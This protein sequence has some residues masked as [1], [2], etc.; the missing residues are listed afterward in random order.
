[1]YPLCRIRI[2]GETVVALPNTMYGLGTDYSFIMRTFFFFIRQQL[3][4]CRC[5]VDII[6]EGFIVAVVLFSTS[7]STQ[8]HDIESSQKDLGSQVALGA[9]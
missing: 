4:S 3:L 5:P 8:Y 6:R 9:S 1:M 7:F 2:S